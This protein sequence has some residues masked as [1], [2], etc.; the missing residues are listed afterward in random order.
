VDLL[1]PQYSLPF[2]RIW[3]IEAKELPGSSPPFNLV[4]EKRGKEA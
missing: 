2:I 4:V 3:T 1:D